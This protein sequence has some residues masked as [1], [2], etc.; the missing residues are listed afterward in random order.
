MKPSLCNGRIRQ[1]LSNEKGD[2]DVETDDVKS[3]LE[4][5]T[6]PVLLWRTLKKAGRAT[7]FAIIQT[8]G[9]GPCAGTLRHLLV[10]S[11]R[12]E[13]SAR[14]CPSP[15]ISGDGSVDSPK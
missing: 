7:K 8:D 13:L 9:K 6:K 2:G 3:G 1:K 5:R 12:L 10:D 11:V 15:E 14:Q 4:N